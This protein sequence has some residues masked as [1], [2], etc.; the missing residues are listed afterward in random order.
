MHPL[1]RAAHLL[2]WV[3][4]V[5][6][7]AMWLGYRNRAAVRVQRALFSVRGFQ[8]AAYEN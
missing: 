8:G 4:P 3:N 6:L 5:W 1:D 2:L 7:A